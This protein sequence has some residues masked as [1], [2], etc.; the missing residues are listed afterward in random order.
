VRVGFFGRGTAWLGLKG[1]L[2][3]CCPVSAFL[4]SFTETVN[5]WSHAFLEYVRCSQ[6][7]DEFREGQELDAFAQNAVR[8]I[9]VSP[10]HEGGIEGV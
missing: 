7:L 2:S 4:L 6:G 5:L 9:Q 10:A 1:S 3:L 8:F